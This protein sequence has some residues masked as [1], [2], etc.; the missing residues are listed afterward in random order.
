MCVEDGF[1]NFLNAR[2]AGLPP[3]PS[4]QQIRLQTMERDHKLNVYQHTAAQLR[5]KVQKLEKKLASLGQEL[6]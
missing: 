4:Q 5:A 1:L 6:S 2:V 3:A